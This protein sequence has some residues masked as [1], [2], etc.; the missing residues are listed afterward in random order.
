MRISGEVGDVPFAGAWQPVKGRWYLM[1]SKPLLKAGGFKVGD[2]VEVRFR[3]EAQDTVAVPDALRRALER[4]RTRLKRWEALS[5]GKRRG[6]AHRVASARTL[7]TEQKRVAE[8]LEALTGR[9]GPVARSS[10]ARSD[11]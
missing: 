1:L 4:D 9:G 7:A 5:P 3:V 6:L 8:V 2:L 11:P 10:P